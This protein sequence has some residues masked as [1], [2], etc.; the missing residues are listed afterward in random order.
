MSVFLTVD[1]GGALLDDVPLSEPCRRYSAPSISAGGFCRPALSFR[2]CF[3]TPF[4]P[5]EPRVRPG[6]C[7]GKG[8]GETGHGFVAY[9]NEIPQFFEKYS[10]NFKN[11]RFFTR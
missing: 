10:E 6:A 11:R 4:C 2:V 9:L 5:V 3:F 7:R 8:P 1:L